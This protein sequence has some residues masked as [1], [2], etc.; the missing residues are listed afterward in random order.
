MV[1]SG[2]EKDTIC[3]RTSCTRPTTYPHPDGSDDNCN[4]CEE[5]SG[6]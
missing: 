3:L 2:F 1:S 4:F 5:E 6:A